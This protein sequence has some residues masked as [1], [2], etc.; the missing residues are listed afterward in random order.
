MC[1]LKAFGRCVG[2]NSKFTS[3]YHPQAPAERANRQV[4]EA[5]RAAL[6][7]VAQ[8]DDWDLALPHITFGLNTHI[9]TTDK[10]SP[11]ERMK[12]RHWAT[13][14]HMA[15]AQARLGHLLA[16]RSRPATLILGGLVWMDSR[17][18]PN[19]IP[20]KLTARWFG[21]FAVLQFKGAQATLDLPSIFGQA[22]GQVN[23]ARLKFFEPRDSKLGDE[24]LR[25]QP[26]WGHDG[27]PHYEISRMCNARCHK[28]V[29]EL[30]VEWKG[31]DQSRN[32]WVARS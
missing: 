20:F 32:G 23:T 16:K 15:T 24:N 7:T 29:D 6:A 11:F 2:V 12:M 19:Y 22:H 28:G 8:Y 5:L 9:S 13:A 3:S 27:V 26:L 21:P 4:M 10:L 31:Y 17:H 1:H 14:D 30:W 18:T 25:P